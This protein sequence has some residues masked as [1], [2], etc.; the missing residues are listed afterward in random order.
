MIS[1]AGV[2]LS[3]WTPQAAAWAERHIPTSAIFPRAGSDRSPGFDSVG[4][5]A[6]GPWSPPA[7][8]PNVLTW[9]GGMTGWATFY[10]IADSTQLAAIRTALG[11]SGSGAGWAVGTFNL[12]DGRAVRDLG[13]GTL[14]GSASRVRARMYMLEPIPLSGIDGELSLVVLVDERYKHNQN[15]VTPTNTDSWTDLIDQ[16]M[17]AAGWQSDGSGSGAGSGWKYGTNGMI[18]AAYGTP[19]TKWKALTNEPCGRV[20]DAIALMTQR[21]WHLDYDGKPTLFGPSLFGQDL[22]NAVNFPD[23][24]AGVCLGPEPLETSDDGAFGTYETADGRTYLL[25]TPLAGRRIPVGDICRTL[26]AAALVEWDGGSAEV[27]LSSLLVSPYNYHPRLA[28][29]SGQTGQKGYV[30]VDRGE[31]TEAERALIAGQYYAR[32]QADADATWGG[33]V[34]PHLGYWCAGIRWVHDRQTVRTRYQRPPVEELPPLYPVGDGFWAKITKKTYTAGWYVAYDWERVTDSDLPY[35]LN[36]TNGC[37]VCG[38]S[39]SGS[40]SGSGGGC[41]RGSFG[42]NP[43]YEVNNVDL[44]VYCGPDNGGAGSGSGSGSG[45]GGGNGIEPF[46][47]R[48]R[49]GTGAYYL[50]EQQPRWEFV[51]RSGAADGQGRFPGVLLRYDQ[52]SKTWVGV[53]EVLIIDANA[54]V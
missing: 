17:D 25:C 34:R 32:R 24:A 44:P 3:L 36:W 16:I 10:G 51:A 1:Y 53:E 41:E 47:V 21:R 15:R 23:E 40:G 35:P 31:P 13:G 18:D 7:V 22:N 39:G 8:Q 45:S 54:A 14:S 50:I 52:T 49:R 9:P 11:G 12:S 38:Q 2:D 19:S 29:C 42:D 5:H 30:R 20:L 43:A 27:T 28:G 4:L 6:P 33:I 37:G 46:I 48:L 26:P